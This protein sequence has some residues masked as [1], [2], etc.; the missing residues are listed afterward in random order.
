MEKDVVSQFIKI[1]IS[2]CVENEDQ[3]LLHKIFD[4][5]KYYDHKDILSKEEK[6]NISDTFFEFAKQLWEKRDFQELENYSSITDQIKELKSE[7]WC[8]PD[9]DQLK[10]LSEDYSEEKDEDRKSFIWAVG[11]S[12]LYQFEVALELCEE[13]LDNI[14]ADSELAIEIRQTMLGW[15]DDCDADETKVLENCKVLAAVLAD[16]EEKEKMVRQILLRSLHDL[17]FLSEFLSKNDD[18]RWWALICNEYLIFGDELIELY[19]KVNP[20]CILPAKVYSDLVNGYQEAEKFDTADIIL[21]QFK[22]H[23]PVEFEAGD[24]KVKSLISKGSFEEALSLIEQKEISEN[25]YI[26]KGKILCNLERYEESINSFKQCG[27]SALYSSIQY[28]VID[29]LFLSRL[30]DAV[31]FSIKCFE[32]DE[33]FIWYL[34][35]WIGS[36]DPGKDFLVKLLSAIET[37]PRTRKDPSYFQEMYNYILD[38]TNAL[39]PEER[40]TVRFDLL[41]TYVI[42][43]SI[44]SQLRVDLHTVNSIF[45]YSTEKSLKYLPAYSDKIGGS[46]FRMGNVAY[47]NDPEEGKVFG[48]IVGE[49]EDPADDFKYRNAYLASFSLKSDSLPMWVQYADDAK[50]C[51]YEIDTTPFLYNREYELEDHIINSSYGK[52]H[53]LN[54]VGYTLYRVHYYDDKKE[55]E[56]TDTCKML[57]EHIEALRPWRKK[58]KID[59]LLN[60]LLDSVRYLFKDPSYQAEEEI[61]IVKIDYDNKRKIDTSGEGLPRLFVEIEIPLVFKKIILGPKTTDIKQKATYLKCCKNVKNVCKSKIK[62]V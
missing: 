27:E 5:K 11:F 42:V 53:K 19:E 44:K 16:P 36:C 48:R 2:W 25:H 14:P 43:S 54:P 33:S 37:K 8:V 29:Y 3:P 40:G 51:C 17:P 55:D 34:S 9:M 57:Q 23:Y 12:E 22:Q 13:I 38:L 60:E 56:I 28:I 46:P 1:A 49:K 10:K 6:W 20:K 62:Y 39:Q 58:K 7:D 15:Y 47:L 59:N 35:H 31:N 61:R 32:N 24:Y 41:R 50:G 26:L 18:A 52:K 30:D 21:E 45:H 4:L